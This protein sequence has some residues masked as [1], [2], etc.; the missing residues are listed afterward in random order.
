MPHNLS[1]AALDARLEALETRLAYQEDWLDTL[2][3]TVIDQQRRLDALEKISA[4]MRE[5]LRERSHEPSHGQTPTP[6]ESDA[7]P[8]DERPPHY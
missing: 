7:P 6:G 8:D 1:P 3:Q 4:L 2:D 5:R